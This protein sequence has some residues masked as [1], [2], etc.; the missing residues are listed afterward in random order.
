MI[1]KRISA[2]ASLRLGLKTFQNGYKNRSWGK[3][4]APVKELLGHANVAATGAD[5]GVIPAALQ[6]RLPSWA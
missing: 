4:L 3:N 5:L 2:Q 6:E 1:K